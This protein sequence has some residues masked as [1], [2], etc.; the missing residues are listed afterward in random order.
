MRLSEILLEGFGV[1]IKNV[2]PS[3]VFDI[4]DGLLINLDLNK[5]LE[6]INKVSGLNYTGDVDNLNYLSNDIVLAKVLGN[7]KA[8]KLY[9]KLLVP[10][11][12]GSSAELSKEDIKD[13]LDGVNN[14]NAQYKAIAKAVEVLNDALDNSIIIYNQYSDKIRFCV[15]KGSTEQ[16]LMKSL[17]ESG[18]QSPLMIDKLHTLMIIKGII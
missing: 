2:R 11:M 7:T 3:Q 4:I 13:I 9:L 16:E 10:I 6:N 5:A 8:T 15:L 17:N 12:L 14:T 18:F 1:N